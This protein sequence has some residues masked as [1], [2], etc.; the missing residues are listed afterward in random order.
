MEVDVGSG[1]E[2]LEKGR[3]NEVGVCLVPQ[4][5]SHS[6]LGST[7]SSYGSLSLSLSLSLSPFLSLLYVL[8]RLWFW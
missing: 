5:W 8:L 2:E 4:P 3:F 1:G 6:S 7:H